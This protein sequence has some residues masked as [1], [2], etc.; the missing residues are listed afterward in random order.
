M[1]P[2][3][4]TLSTGRPFA[5]SPFHD[6]REMSVM[7]RPSNPDPDPREIPEGTARPGTTPPAE[8]GTSTGTGPHRPPRRGWAAGPLVVI[9]SLAVLCAL[10]FLVYAIVLATD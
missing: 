4:S 1:E 6:R 2:D 3:E 10:F 8:S 7:I 5:A 9:C